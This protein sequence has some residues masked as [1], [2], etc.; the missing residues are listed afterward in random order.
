MCVNLQKQ[1]QQGGEVMGTNGDKFLGE[2]ELP[3]GRGIQHQ[4]G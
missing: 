4:L 1:R 3:L 2:K